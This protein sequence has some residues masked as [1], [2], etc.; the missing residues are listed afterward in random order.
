MALIP[1]RILTP[2]Q[3]DLREKLLAHIHDEEHSAIQVKQYR[4]IS[5]RCPGLVGHLIIESKTKLGALIAYSD[6]KFDHHQTDGDW[7]YYEE[8]Y[9]EFFN[10]NL[11]NLIEKLVTELVKEPNQIDPIYT[12]DD[13]LVEIDEITVISPFKKTLIKGSS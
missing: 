6:W 7:E 1:T 13:Y 2:A 4:A 5:S 11:Q 12:E 8:S 10:D 3:S 9:S